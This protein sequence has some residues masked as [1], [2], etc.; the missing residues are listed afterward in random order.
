[1]RISAVQPLLQGRT[2]NLHLGSCGWVFLQVARRLLRANRTSTSKDHQRNDHNQRHEADAFHQ[3]RHLRADRFVS[4]DSNASSNVAAP[5]VGL[6]LLSAL[7]SNHP[8]P[9]APNPS[10]PAPPNRP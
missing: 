2:V 8:P 4:L 6:R 5:H 7:S 10:S 3:R 1:P 9:A